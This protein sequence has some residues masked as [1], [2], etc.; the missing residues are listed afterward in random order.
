MPFRALFILAAADC[1]LHGPGDAK[2]KMAAALAS[3]LA[4]AL[5]WQA[6]YILAELVW[7]AVFVRAWQLSTSAAPPASAA[8]P[9][10]ASPAPAPASNGLPDMPAAIKRECEDSLAKFVKNCG[11][12]TCDGEPWT[13]LSNEGGLVVSSAPYSGKS[14]LRWK[15]EIAEV[16]GPSDGI[17]EELFNYS[18]RCGP[19]GWDKAVAGGRVHKQFADNYKI[20]I[21]ATA[22]ALGGLVTGREF[23][24]ARYV[25]F[26]AEGGL[27]LSGVGLP[28]KPYKQTL[29]ADY[30]V[31]DASLTR[32]LGYPGGGFKLT[33]VGPAPADGKTPGLWKWVLVS[34]VELGGWLPQSSINSATSQ[35]LVESSKETLKHLHELFPRP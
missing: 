12:T 33:P 7:F 22:P 10:A 26:P 34:N 14:F 6:G 32:A 28:E 15:V 24:E 35:V 27:L 16:Y 13:M 18:K 25:T 17:Y 21:Y 23:V 19:N 4:L 2:E 8:P 5:H 11:P 3:V 31:G 9:V 29:G 1:Y 30:P 20:V